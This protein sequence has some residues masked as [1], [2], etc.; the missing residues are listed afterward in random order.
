V[1]GSQRLFDAIGAQLILHRNFADAA[2]R[3]GNEYEIV[4]IIGAGG[5]GL[6][7]R[8]TQIALR[9]T[10][11]LKLF[12]LGEPDDGGVREALREARSLARLEHPGIVGVHAAGES[13][14]IAGESLACAY[15][16]MQL[17]DGVDLRS[18]L[19]S[20]REASEVL[21]LL[22]TAGRALAHAHAAGIVHRDFKPENLMIERSGRV[23]VI[24]FG[25][26]LVAEA[27]DAALAK[28][29]A[30]ADAI[31]TRAT[32]TGVVR[33]TP[34]Y[35][36]P[37]ASQGL[38]RA[39]S[40][41]FALAVVI[42]EALTG[43]HP[44]ATDDGPSG[45]IP[46]GGPELFAKIKPAIDRAMASSPNDRFATIDELCDTVERAADTKPARRRRWPKLA[47][48]AALLGL[49]ASVGWLARD[50]LLAFMSSLVPAP[51][52]A[53]PTP[54]S[55]EPVEP[56]A[57]PPPEPT[58]TACAD[59]QAWMGTWQASIKI[60][61][62]EYAY[63]FDWRIE[64]EFELALG[65]RCQITVT[66]RQYLPAAEGQLPAPPLMATTSAVA[67]DDG[68]GVWRVPLRFAFLDDA[69]TYSSVEFYETVLVLDRA[70]ATPR[71]R[72][73]FRKLNEEGYWIRLGLL[74][75]GREAAPHPKTIRPDEFACAARCRI[76]CAGSDAEKA[77]LDLNCAAQENHAA[78]I[79]GPPSYD[80]AVPMRARA[81]RDAVRN[82]KSPFD[83]AL[84]RG[85]RAK[86]LV[87]CA[88]NART[89]TGSWGLWLADEFATLDVQGQDC[90]LQGTVRLRENS[91]HVS[92]YVTAAGTWV[93]MPSDEPAPSWLS[94]PLVLVGAGEHG[95]AFGTNTANPPQPLRAFRISG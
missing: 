5:F 19:T 75:G 27:G 57:E 54:A 77:C 70:D 94:Y 90:D 42:R 15:V 43:R 10:V 92:G 69:R 32:A 65:E 52:V 81:A 30:G 50:P 63:Q 25:L 34:G 33:G 11:A 55:E 64:Y 88:K 28:W 49:L 47:L 29:Q 85:S 60:I 46:Q 67:V 83:Q 26:A 44:F 76:E 20:E 38:P 1:S 84:E 93:L 62:T 56:P 8:A 78:D 6:I 35:M 66:A 51:R 86:Q 80:F 23:K 73:A 59:L 36:A 37:E 16:E 9:R 89:L 18:W 2:P 95:P 39:A 58:P 3:V 24:D 22:C 31:G 91:A 4:E 79:C 61:W 7:C 12:P 72:G 14:L 17:I 71:L 41:Q 68:T 13:Q 40:D 53:E 21:S 82:G 74:A 45:P 87:E 48:A